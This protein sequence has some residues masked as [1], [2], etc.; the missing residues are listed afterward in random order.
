M[1]I[2]DFVKEF[3]ERL[4]SGELDTSM[5]ERSSWR[6]LTRGQLLGRRFLYRM[7]AYLRM[8]QEQVPSDKCLDMS[9]ESTVDPSIVVMCFGSTIGVRLREL[10][11]ALDA[12]NRNLA[13]LL[14]STDTIAMIR[15]ARSIVRMAQCCDPL[16]VPLFSVDRDTGYP[17]GHVS[18]FEV[19]SSL[20]K[21]LSIHDMAGTPQGEEIVKDLLGILSALLEMIFN[22]DSC[23]SS[24]E[25]AVDDLDFRT[26]ALRIGLLT[27]P[28]EVQLVAD[29]V[30][31]IERLA[32]ELLEN[33]EL[34]KGVVFR[35]IPAKER[36]AI[37]WSLLRLFDTLEQALSGKKGEDMRMVRFYSERDMSVWA[38]SALALDA[39][40]AQYISNG[41][42][43]DA[44]DSELAT[45]QKL[46]DRRAFVQHTKLDKFRLIRGDK[47]QTLLKYTVTDVNMTLRNPYWEVY[48]S[49]HVVS[50]INDIRWLIGESGNIRLSN[51]EWSIWLNG[52]LFTTSRDSESLAS[53]WAMLNSVEECVLT[54]A[55]YSKTS[56]LLKL[57]D[58]IRGAWGGSESDLR[59]LVKVDGVDGLLVLKVFEALMEKN[60]PMAKRFLGTGNM[61]DVLDLKSTSY[62]EE[63]FKSLANASLFADNGYTFWELIS[64]PFVGDGKDDALIIVSR[65]CIEL[66]SIVAKLAVPE[67]T[68]DTILQLWVSRN[69]DVSFITF[70]AISRFVFP[71]ESITDYLEFFPDVIVYG[72]RFSHDELLHHARIMFIA[73]F[74]PYC[75]SVEMRLDP[76]ISR[77]DRSV[78]TVCTSRDQLLQHSFELFE[79]VLVD[80]NSWKTTIEIEFTGEDG[81]DHG[82]LRKEWYYLVALEILKGDNGITEETEEGSGRYTF[83]PISYFSGN[84]KDL[85]EFVGKFVAKAML[86]RQVL[87]IRFSSAMYK[88]I[89]EGLD[90]VQLD[91]D[92]YSQQSPLHAQ[93]LSW[94]LENQVVEGLSFAVDIVEAGT[95]RIHD[96]VPGGSSIPVTEDNKH[97]Y[98]CLM[99]E[100]KM[101]DSVRGRLEKFLSGFYSVINR[102][103]LNGRFS[104]DELE[105]LISD[106]GDGIDLEDLEANTEL[107]GY[108]DSSPQIEWFWE[109]VSSFDQEELGLLVKFITGSPIPPPGGF[110]HLRGGPNQ[111][112]SCISIAIVA[113]DSA[114]PPLPSSHTCINQLNL[115]EYASIDEL[116][117]KLTMAISEAHEGFTFA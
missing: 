27:N 47:W 17:E 5:S 113:T 20:R 15:T 37:A 98:V 6:S 104:S 13:L 93:S 67:S 97:E 61:E 95:H 81:H 87:P 12:G 114:A 115:P 50:C 7:D 39:L 85:A 33:E 42:G 79:D 107:I 9:L 91:L 70:V 21:L 43:M 101:R 31:E 66:A 73:E 51:G 11:L 108:T 14:S 99:I 32:Q 64:R 54:L 106:A 56:S 77:S 8:I 44:I 88:F 82:G 78:L 76:F 35:F 75:V 105:L 74:R 94:I 46:I 34:F 89:L 40:L 59:A 92:M 26:L 110:A 62:P 45:I 86:D 84:D 111:T 48:Y 69:D 80:L 63:Y 72:D 109:V 52:M 16:Y 24:G 57:G 55:A 96:L 103:I 112:A 65:A 117:Q 36:A 90:A 49:P 41:T 68:R 18:P 25:L 30:A 58:L 38:K 3:G 22:A 10:G 2:S 29:P 116:R 1:P 23:R 100:Y 60:P 19:E 102:D 53:L 83:A 28:R 71:I 4:S